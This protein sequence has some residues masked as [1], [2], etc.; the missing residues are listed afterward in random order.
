V[1]DAAV[2]G[3]QEPAVEHVVAG[4]L[5]KITQVGGVIGA[6]W[7]DPYDRPVRRQ[8]ID[9]AVAVRSAERYDR[10]DERPARLTSCTRNIARRQSHT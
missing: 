5:V 7:T 3:G 10:R 9:T 1:R 6:G 4:A 2:T 8:R